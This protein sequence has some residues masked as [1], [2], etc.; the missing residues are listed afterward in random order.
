[1]KPKLT[2]KEID[3]TYSYMDGTDKARKC[4]V[5]PLSK[6]CRSKTNMKSTRHKSI[7]DWNALE[8]AVGTGTILLGLLFV[9][10]KDW[11]AVALII[12]GI[13]LIVKEKRR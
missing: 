10:L 9:S 1:M 8:Y 12:A 2:Q 13:Y 4:E 5:F 11:N 3:E 7:I 6:C